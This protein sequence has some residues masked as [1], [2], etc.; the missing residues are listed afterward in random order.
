MGDLSGPA[1][2]G[3]A[4]NRITQRAVNPADTGTPT[5]FSVELLSLGG[6]KPEVPVRATM[7][8]SW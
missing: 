2:P 5:G 1:Q 3:A 8:H 6:I 7:T 4:S